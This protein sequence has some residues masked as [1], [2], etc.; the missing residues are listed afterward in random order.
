MPVD[1][2]AIVALRDDA[3]PIH[4]VDISQQGAGF[5]YDRMLGPAP[6]ST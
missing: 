6:R 1:V 3:R 2:E 4:L 5:R